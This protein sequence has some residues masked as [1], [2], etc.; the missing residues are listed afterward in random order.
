MKKKEIPLE[1]L[2]VLVDDTYLE[3]GKIKIK[4][5]GASAGHNGLLSIEKELGSREW[6]RIRI[7]VG[8][9]PGGKYRTDYVLSKPRPEL[10]QFYEKGKELALAALEMILTEGVERAMTVFN[11]RRNS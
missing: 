10:I 7:G 9:D 5:S 3:M 4:P 1:K 11:A 6:T 8:P 2:I